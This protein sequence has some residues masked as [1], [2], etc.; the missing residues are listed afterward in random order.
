MAARLL[1]KDDVEGAVARLE[2]MLSPGRCPRSAVA[3]T[4]SPQPAPKS[5]VDPSCSTCAFIHRVVSAF[6]LPR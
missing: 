1:A 4:L 2:R 3:P 5:I 6:R